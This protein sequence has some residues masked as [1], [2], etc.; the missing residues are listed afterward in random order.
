MAVEEEVV[1][2]VALVALAEVAVAVAVAVAAEDAVNAEDVMLHATNVAYLA[3]MLAIVPTRL[4]KHKTA[5]RIK[6]P[7]LRDL[8][9]GR[10]NCPQ[11]GSPKACKRMENN[12]KSATS[13]LTGAS[14]GAKAT[15]RTPHPNTRQ[16]HR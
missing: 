15:K 14:D 5:C 16:V 1:V 12:G 3:T 13:A 10:K 7:I 4:L 8:L 9:P 11:T 2:V 6:L